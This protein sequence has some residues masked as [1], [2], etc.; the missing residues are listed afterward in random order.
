LGNR[1]SQ[2]ENRAVTVVIDHAVHV[3]Q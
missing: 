1:N 2:V 3:S